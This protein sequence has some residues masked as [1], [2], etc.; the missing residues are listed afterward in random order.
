VAFRLDPYS[1]TARGVAIVL[2]T[3]H[4]G[5][6]AVMIG[7][8]CFSGDP[9][10][11]R[12]WQVLTAVTGAALT[13]TEMSHSRHWVYQGRGL[14]CLT[15]ILLAGLAS[16]EVWRGAAGVALVVGGIGSHLP[17]TIRKWS[18]RHRQVLE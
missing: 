2:R 5:A 17:R 1:N 6:M 16:H 10:T 9:S 8:L 7:A 18:L 4:L 11:L 15:H 12:L 3:G 13:V 14:I